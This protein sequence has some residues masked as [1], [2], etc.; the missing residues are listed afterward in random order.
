MREMALMVNIALSHNLFIA[1]THIYIY[2]YI[3]YI[4]GICFG[5]VHIFF[6]EV[7]FTLTMFCLWFCPHVFVVWFLIVILWMQG[8]HRLDATILIFLFV[9]GQRAGQSQ[10]LYAIVSF[11]QKC[12]WYIFQAI[13][14]LGEWRTAEWNLIGFRFV[15]S[16][17][18]FCDFVNLGL[19]VL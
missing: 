9:W 2:I 5:R 10:E 14:K 17:Q 6:C 16:A 1:R 7:A 11:T 19:C 8:S 4:F 12:S 15:L 18:V 3:L 13:T